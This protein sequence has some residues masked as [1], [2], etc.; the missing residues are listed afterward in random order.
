[1]PSFLAAEGLSF[2]NVA[3]TFW[4]YPSAGWHCCSCLALSGFDRDASTVDWSKEAKCH[5]GRLF[6]SFSLGGQRGG[7]QGARINAVTD[8]KFKKCCSERG[9]CFRG[10]G[11]LWAG[12]NVEGEPLWMTLFT[13]AKGTQW[14]SRKCGWTGGRSV[15]PSDCMLRGRIPWEGCSDF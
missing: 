12:V 2:C 15:Q 7:K 3:P 10:S 8:L 1:M 13:P 14:N 9:Q 11:F 4:A 6:W 5:R